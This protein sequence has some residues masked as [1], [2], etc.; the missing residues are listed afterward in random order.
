MSFYPF[1]LSKRW[2]AEGLPTAAPTTY[3]N[4]NKKYKRR[5]I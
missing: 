3:I 5:E 2:G 1:F 4:R